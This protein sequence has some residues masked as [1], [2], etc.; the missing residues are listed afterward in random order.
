MKH[1]FL[2]LLLLLTA[3]AFCNES[4]GQITGCVQDESNGK[5]PGVRVEISAP[6]AQKK[7]LTFT[8]ESGCYKVPV[9]AGTYQVNFDLPGF[10]TATKTNVIVY[11]GRDAIVDHLLRISVKG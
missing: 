2:C 4:T 3:K 6:K 10:N 5:L 7:I 8:N 11:N 9:P 1:I